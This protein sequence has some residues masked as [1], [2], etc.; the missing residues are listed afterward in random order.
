MR[1]IT[2]QKGRWTIKLSWGALRY[3]SSQPVT[4]PV[5]PIVPIRW[6]RPWPAGRR[7]GKPNAT[8]RGDGVRATRKDGRPKIP[9]ASLTD[10]GHRCLPVKFGERKVPGKLACLRRCNLSCHRLSRKVIDDHDN[11]GERVSTMPRPIDQASAQRQQERRERAAQ[12]E[13]ERQARREGKRRERAERRE[14]KKIER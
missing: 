13:Q 6:L 3:G 2:R 5:E 12:R 4:L 14:Q 11:Y 8:E 10:L 7:S 1:G 9:A